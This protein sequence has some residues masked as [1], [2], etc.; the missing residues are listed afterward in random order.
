[1]ALDRQNYLFGRV[2]KGVPFRSE[3][4]EFRVN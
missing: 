1:M 2:L 4:A 3:N